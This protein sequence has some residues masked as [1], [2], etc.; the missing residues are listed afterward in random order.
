MQL[1]SM[2]QHQSSSLITFLMDTKGR[3]IFFNIV[4]LSLGNLY[5]PSGTDAPTRAQR[6]NHFAETIPQLLLNRLDAGLIGGDMSCITH[7]LDCTH[8]PES[9]KSPSLT[10]LI[11]TF[12]MVDTYR[13][14]FPGRKIFSHY[15]SY[16]QAGG[17]GGTRIDRSYNWGDITVHDAR[18]LPVAFS[19]HMA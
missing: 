15:Y 13:S 6:E 2:G 8:H 3:A 16:G 4:P 14:K 9:K 11:R 5:L 7:N 10:R 17:Q 1:P 18:Y 19:D 12:D